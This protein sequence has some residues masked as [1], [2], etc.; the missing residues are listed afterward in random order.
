MEG[1][2]SCSN[3][4]ECFGRYVLCSADFSVPCSH[5]GWV[6]AVL[7]GPTT[8]GFECKVKRLGPYTETL[9]IFANRMQA[10]VRYALFEALMETLVTAQES[11]FCKGVV[12]WDAIEI[13]LTPE[14]IISEEKEEAEMKAKAK[15]AEARPK[16]E[17]RLSAATAAAEKEVMGDGWAKVDV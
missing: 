7:N 3:L 4:L 16:A 17:A 11:G 14:T 5:L 10:M 12:L 9:G 2:G 8:H 13:P 1:G 6:L 15:A